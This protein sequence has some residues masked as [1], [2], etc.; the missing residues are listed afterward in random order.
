[1]HFDEKWSTI[2]WKSCKNLFDHF[3]PICMTE[4]N[5]SQ[6]TTL[7]RKLRKN[8]VS[9]QRCLSNP[10]NYLQCSVFGKIVNVFSAEAAS[11]RSSHWRCSVTKSVLRN[12]I[13]F[14][15]KHLCQSLFLTKLQA[16]ACHV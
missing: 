12:F 11:I 14:T 10:V 2:L 9:T 13:K 16:K 7:T 5:T 8:F 1:M 3:S 15:G 6:S 4:L